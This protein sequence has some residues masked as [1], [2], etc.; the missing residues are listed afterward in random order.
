V[1]T[2]PRRLGVSRGDQPLPR[3]RGD[4]HGDGSRRLRTA[5]RGGGPLAAGRPRRVGRGRDH[6]RGPRGP[7]HHELEPGSGAALRI[8]RSGGRRPSHLDSRAGPGR[9]E[10]HGRPGRTAGAGRD[11]AGRDRPSQEGRLSGR[12]RGHHLAGARQ[13][14]SDRRQPRSLATSRRRSV[15][16]KRCS[17]RR[18]S[19]ARSSRAAPSRTGSS[20][21]GRC[22]SSRSTTPPS[23]RTAIRAKSSWA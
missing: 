17:L 22:A 3:S 23:G 14:G 12:R 4:R 10:L 9:R 18:R 5:T 7:R 1:G 13:Y 8:R 16:R 2:P 11:R 19:T 15:L 21:P 6:Q 20:T